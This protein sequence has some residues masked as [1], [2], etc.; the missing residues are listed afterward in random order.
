LQDQPENE[1][2][3]FSLGKSLLNTRN[4]KE[5]EVHLRKA[6]DIKPDWMV[7][8]ILLAQCAMKR[9][10]KAGAKHYYEYAL[11]LAIRQKHEGPEQEIREAL[12]VLAEMG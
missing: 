5:A 7:V 10:D 11:P 6:L 8:A 3:H 2:L 12:G 1:L 9:E 4:F